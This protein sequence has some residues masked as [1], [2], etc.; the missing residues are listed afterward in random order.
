MP[1]K[2]SPDRPA[3]MQNETHEIEMNQPKTPLENQ[4]QTYFSNFHDRVLNGMPTHERT[5]NDEKAEAAMNYAYE[6]LLRN[7]AMCDLIQSPDY[8]QV[9]KG[10]EKLKGPTKIGKIYCID[11]R[12]ARIYESFVINT[13]EKAAGLIRADRRQSDNKLIPSSASLCES[14]TAKIDKERPEVDLLEI[15]AAHYDSTSPAHG[16]AAINLIRRA[17]NRNENEYE[18]ATTEEKITI[19]EDLVKKSELEEIL[20][21]DQIKLLLD[22][23][24]PEEA[25]LQ[26]L[27][28]VNVEAITNYYNDVRTQKGLKP[29]ERV[30]ISALYDTATMGLELRYDGDRISTTDLTNKYQDQLQKYG[31]TIGCD[32]GAYRNVLTD[33]SLFI[34]FSHKLLELET[35]LI[36]NEN[37]KFDNIHEDVDTYFKNH[38]DN[39]TPNQKQ[40]L[41]FKMLRK[42]A[43]QHLTGLSQIPASGHPEHPFAH[44]NEAYISISIQGQ[45]VGK[46]DLVEQEF[47]TS[48]ADTN[49]AIKETLVA[50][51]VMDTNHLKE[52]ETRVVYVCS[53][54][55]R[56][57]WESNTEGIRRARANNAELVRGIAKDD[58]LKDL[59]KDAKIIP[60]PV[61]LDE[62]RR[63]LEIPDHSAYF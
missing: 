34:E 28:M 63:V 61:I 31:E 33:P 6:V 59:M 17:L 29:L 1:D 54:A 47:G 62:T 3:L 9:R 25:N 21:R 50:N 40:A 52:D 38:L 5:K 7:D 44:H 39:L 58:K 36:E 42:V 49:T 19:E 30:G 18:T 48:P 35:E 13:W 37:G 45:F 56:S 12:I 4:L 14:I 60:I 32:F 11:G 43:F 22:A 24:T 57:D 27:E 20:T 53:S 51:L 15:S 46:Y 23:P 2:M 16:C 41:R 55:S 8:L 26:I 10:E